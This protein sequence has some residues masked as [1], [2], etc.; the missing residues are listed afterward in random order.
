MPRAPSL[1]ALGVQVMFCFPFSQ[2]WLS[3]LL[4]LQSYLAERRL[5]GFALQEEIHQPL[6]VILA[7]DLEGLG[8]RGTSLRQDGRGS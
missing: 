5:L 4:P 1:P 2:H 6:Q 3:P 7:V 8:S